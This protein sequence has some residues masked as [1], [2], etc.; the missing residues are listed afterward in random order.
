[1]CKNKMF[2]V[3]IELL[4]LFSGIL[5]IPMYLSNCYF[6]QILKKVPA[7]PKACASKFLLLK[8]VCISMTKRPI[9]SF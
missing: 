2:N 3:E 6:P 7:Y 4:T 5:Y 1:M 9:Y 8:N